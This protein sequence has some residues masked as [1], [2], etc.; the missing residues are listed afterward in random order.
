MTIYQKI[1][2]QYGLT[3]S[4]IS[5]VLGFG[6]NVWGTYESESSVPNRSNNLLIQMVKDPK[7][8]RKLILSNA[9]LRN[10]QTGELKPRYSRIVKQIDNMVAKYHGI[11][12]EEYKKWVESLYE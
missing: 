10:S 9:Q 2:E 5:K 12:G 11:E 4:G 1:R 7:S 3:K 6:Q 8:M